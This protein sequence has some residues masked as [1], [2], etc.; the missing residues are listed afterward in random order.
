MIE[1]KT[2]L[3][4]NILNKKIK[5]LEKLSFLVV[6]SLAILSLLTGAYDINSDDFGWYIFKISRI[7]RT[8]AVML[9]GA[10]IS[11]CGLTMQILT[12]NKMVDSTTTGTVE[13]SGLGLVFAYIFIPSPSLLHRT[14]S[15]IVFSFI[16]TLIFFFLIKKI[17]IKSSLI[18]PI[19]GMM[20]GAV[21]S[22]VSTFIGLMFNAR[23]T[24]SVWFSGSFTNIESGRYEI[25]WIIVFITI[26]LY[27]FAD[28]ITLAGLGEDISVSLGLDYEKII[29]IATILI[30]LTIGIVSSVIGNIPFLG[31]IVPNIVSRISG[32]NLRTNLPLVTLFGMGILLFADIL[33]RIIISPF[34]VP[35]SLIMGTFGSIIF[36]IILFKKRSKDVK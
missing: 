27:V 9:T 3:K 28:K 11:I 6:V 15:S 34:E 13:W 25:L 36:L 8:L 5:Y 26:L 22:S 17:R 23:Q 2:I 16:G 14:I 30:S 12:R 18:V 7:S 29:L 1:K 19:I 33:S 32:D 35:V 20:L 4:N 24:V 21:I 31:L 10:A